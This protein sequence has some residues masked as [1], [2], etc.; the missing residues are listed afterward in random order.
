MVFV[1]KGISSVVDLTSRRGYSPPKSA[2]AY[3][4][5]KLVALHCKLHQK[6]KKK[7]KKKGFGLLV[8]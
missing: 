6:K 5:T 3:G 8:T 7:K 2:D 1:H 4:L